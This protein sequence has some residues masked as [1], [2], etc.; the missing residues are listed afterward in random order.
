MAWVDSEYA[1][2]L[3]VVAAWLSA[4][5]P[6]SVSLR[7]GTLLGENASLV[8]VRFPV[9]MFQFL[10]GPDVQG[11][12]SFVPVW[13]AQ[14]ATTGASAAT[15]TQLWLAGAVLVGVAFVFSLLYYARDELVEARSPLDPVR[16]MGALLTLGGGLLLASALLLFDALPGLTLPVGGLIVPALGLALLVVERAD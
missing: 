11:F 2:E 9:A 15:A 10:F 3:A 6:W 14:S 5:L 8:V 12:D 1:G 7:S 4:L 16:V 13:S